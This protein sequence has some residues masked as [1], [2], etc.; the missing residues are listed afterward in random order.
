MSNYYLAPPP[1]S[2]DGKQQDFLGWSREAIQQG[3]NFLR[4]QPAYP[5]IQQGL[6]IIN[7]EFAKSTVTT[8]S[9]AKTELMTRNLKELVAAQTNIRII[10]AFSTQNPDF[11]KQQVVLNK[12]Y[13]AWQS[14]TFADRKIRSAWQYACAAGTGYL[15]IRFE[16]NYYFK[17]AGEIVL[18]A[19]GPLDVIP[20]GLPK[21]HDLQKAYMT[22]VRV[23][24]PYH[25]VIQRYPQFRDQIT[26][27]REGGQM[28]GGV[29]SK[30]AKFA[31]SALR[32]FAQG[33]SPDSEESAWAMVD[34]YN[35]YIQDMS[36]NTTGHTL[37]MGVPGSSWAYEVPY[38]GQRIIEGYDVSMQP[39]FREAKPEDCLIYPNGRMVPVTDNLV[40]EPD[41]TLQ[42]N[43]YWHSKTPIIQLR[44]DDWAW[45][46]LGFPVT[47]AGASLEKANIEMMRG[48]V[49]TINVRLSPPRAYDR[50]TM[51]KSLAETINPRIPNQVVGL[52]LAFSGS[53]QMKPLLPPEYYNVPVM[54]AEL[55]QANESRI[56][57]QMGVADAVALSRARQL[58]SGD[59]LE[60][61]MDSMGPLIKDQSRNMESSIRDL[62]ELWKFCTFQFTTASKRVQ[63]LGA[64]GD[65]LE[66]Y[67]Y[68]PGNLVPA[69]MPND[70]EWKGWDRFKRAR[71]HAGQFTF[72]ITPYSLHELNSITRKL[73]HLQLSRAG[74]PIDWWTLADVFDVKNFGEK[75]MVDDPDNEGEK[76]RADTVLECYIAQ[77][78]I[79]VRIMAAQQGVV[80]QAKAAAQSSGGTAPPAPGHQMGRPPSGQ[81]PPVLEQKSDGRSTIRESKH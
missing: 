69:E 8:I 70:S 45:N 40:L 31:T 34:V 46:F 25:E 16:P 33:S 5:Y 28:P 12:L 30:V 9:D 13:L 57:H 2:T 26:P 60:R 72:Q 73:F 11:T 67:D 61:I 80:E 29:I 39:V 59:S 78:E 18:D 68:E 47:K 6:D 66:D 3:S 44:A 52:D 10:P 15:G 62:G 21:S 22:A 65:V 48:V 58:P 64:S 36:I 43:P 19:Y 54:I 41:P 4:L 20:L 63:I 37:H 53:D 17:G 76:K 38:I 74:F 27:S 32:K 71:K 77:K 56:T 75:P 55:I 1:F 7:G 81:N 79:E 14:M 50:N 23:A 42:V 24:T 51:S 49:D 35:L